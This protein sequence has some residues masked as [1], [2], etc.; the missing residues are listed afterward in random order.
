MCAGARGDVERVEHAGELQETN[1]ARCA[2]TSKLWNNGKV[3]NI[4]KDSDGGSA[5][6]TELRVVGAS[7]G[8]DGIGRSGKP[9]LNVGGRDR[10]E[11]LGLVFRGDEDLI[12]V[13]G[14][15]ALLVVS[16]EA[17][18]EGIKIAGLI[19]SEGKID[20]YSK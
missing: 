18:V 8:G 11:R 12:L 20:G 14:G 9:S 19:T 15:A 10:F 16:D 17:C 5:V 4:G 6:L 13:R 2:T 7:G 1:E 3:V